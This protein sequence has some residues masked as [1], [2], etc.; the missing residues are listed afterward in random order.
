M[1]IVIIIFFGL[2][3]FLFLAFTNF[4]QLVKI[5][6]N[7][8]KEQWIKD[9]KPIGF[10]WRP[11][12][13]NWFGSSIAMQRL[14]MRWIFRTPNWATGDPQAKIYLRKLRIFV[15]TWNVGMIIWFMVTMRL[16]LK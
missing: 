2:V 12:E 6:Y 5:E 14:S 15:L 1:S 13:S 4:D 7:K 11:P 16:L 3:A 9:G 8:Y 10:F